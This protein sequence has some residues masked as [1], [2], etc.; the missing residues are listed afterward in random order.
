MVV[1]VEPLSNTLATLQV[2][3]S[4][5]GVFGVIGSSKGLRPVA[6]ASVQLVGSRHKAITDSTGRFVIEAKTG[7]VYIVRVSASGYGDDVSSVVVPSF[8]MVE[9][10]RLLDSAG[11]PQMLEWMWE[12]ADKRMEWRGMNSAVVPA[13]QLTRYG[14]SLLDALQGSPA[15]VR[16]GLRISPAS[17]IYVDGIQRAGWPLTSVRPEDVEAVE[18]YGRRG[19][20][21]NSLKPC[22]GGGVS[23]TGANVASMVV[24]WLKHP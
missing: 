21:T 12:E 7:G 14:G 5:T 22:T 15:V 19:D 11:G 24:I 16:S 2:R 8:R 6:G 13:E 1:A 20:P 17:C 4:A 18:V 3:D 9:A 23:Y 10:S